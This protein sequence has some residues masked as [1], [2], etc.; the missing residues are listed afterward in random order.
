MT[1]SYVVVFWWAFLLTT[2]TCVYSMFTWL[3]WYPWVI[4][5]LLGMLMIFSCWSCHALVY[6]WYILL[7]LSFIV[8]FYILELC[9]LHDAPTTFSLNWLWTWWM[10]SMLNLHFYDTWYCDM[11]CLLCALLRSLLFMYLLCH[12][13][14]MYTYSA[15]VILIIVTLILFQVIACSHDCIV[16]SVIFWMI[17]FFGEYLCFVLRY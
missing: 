9:T 10:S 5:F 6:I 12:A 7:C 8:S 3:I 17:T 16:L 2:V 15:I 4:T 13:K 1:L 14:L 11:F